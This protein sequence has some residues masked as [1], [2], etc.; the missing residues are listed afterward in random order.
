MVSLGDTGVNM[1]NDDYDYQ[2]HNASGMY[3][4]MLQ[5]RPESIY[6]I[7]FSQSFDPSN[8]EDQYSSNAMSYDSYP[9]LSAYRPFYDA[10]PF[11]VNGPQDM[12]KQQQQQQQY[13]MPTPEGSPAHS[14]SHSFD[15]P[16]S[17]LSSSGASVP[18]AASS[19]MSSPYSSGGHV[20][21]HGVDSWPDTT[22]QGLGIDPSIVQPSSYSSDG[23]FMT[24]LPDQLLFDASD[25][26]SA[27]VGECSQI[28][29][30]PRAMTP[31]PMST[32]ARQSSALTV[33]LP[34]DVKI[35]RSSASDSIVGNVLEEAA[36]GG[37]RRHTAPT[38]DD[39]VFKSPSTPASARSSFSFSPRSPSRTPTPTTRRPSL[40]P[41]G[42]AKPRSKI[43]T[44]PKLPSS[45]RSPYRS[46]A[47]PSAPT[48]TYAGF[49]PS[50]FF[51]QSSGNFIAPLQ[52]SCWFPNIPIYPKP[53]IP[54]HSFPFL[55]SSF[56]FHFSFS[57]L[58]AICLHI[59]HTHYK[60]S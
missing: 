55:S 9:T 1:F 19:A 8:L 22:T 41:T 3:T 30:S 51:S 16:P 37:R 18:S 13:L 46:L 45:G 24:S 26:I 49:H 10:T 20:L 38:R 25:K 7:P 21:H 59:S 44:S 50:P 5:S 47:E 14:S 53:T 15:P 17:S 23:G 33:S 2:G 60:S 54:F 29:S 35:E 6:N 4:D 28:S 48:Q 52:A 32:L 58:V 12:S 34:L 40:T 43:P 56:F 57:F 36:S 31:V 11:V 42:V 27:F 39:M